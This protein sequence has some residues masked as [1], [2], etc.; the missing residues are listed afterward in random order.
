MTRR[1]FSKVLAGLVA[2]LILPLCL[3]AGVAQ[4]ETQPVG[5]RFSG[6]SAP[7]IFAGLQADRERR[8]E[9]YDLGETRG[10]KAAR[11]FKLSMSGMGMELG[12]IFTFPF[13]DPKTT[14]AFLLG[15]AALIAVDRQTTEWWQDEVEPIFDD[16]TIP[17]SRSGPISV[18]SKIVLG[19]VGLTYAGG[20]AFNDERAQTAALL[21]AKAIGY[22]Y[23]VSQVV[24]KPIFGRLRPIDGLSGC[25]PNADH[26]DLTCDPWDFGHGGGN[27]PWAGGV[28]ATSM[29]SFHFTQYFA[30]ARVYS[31]VYDNYWIPYTAAGLMSAVNIRGHNHWVSDM[32]AGALIGTGI[33]NVILNNYD[34]R[35]G[36]ADNAYLIPIVSSDGVGFSFSMTF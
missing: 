23:A 1:L 12:Q 9:Y 33:G 26:G 15:T 30:V 24:L 13:R 17:Q 34:E 28:H 8:F 10:E 11:T 2:G 20:V 19:A 29:P 3:S 4:A 16:F 36:G 14:G 22:S 27:I 35:K 32:V 25:D 31:G 18:E 5:L 6:Y 21:S 7:K